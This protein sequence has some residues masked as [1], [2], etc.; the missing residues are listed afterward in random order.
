MEKYATFEIYRNS[1]TGEKIQ[2][3]IG[4]AH[5]G[6]GWVRDGDEEIKT[7]ELIKEGK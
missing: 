7:A 1:E 4:D 6:K 3:R 5:P 2:I